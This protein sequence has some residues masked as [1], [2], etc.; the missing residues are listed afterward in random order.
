L[1]SLLTQEQKNKDVE[2]EA[3]AAKFKKSI[4]FKFSQVTDERTP[5]LSDSEVNAEIADKPK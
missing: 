4:H 3:L 2:L 1:C 5:K